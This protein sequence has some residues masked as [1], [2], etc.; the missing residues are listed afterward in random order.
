MIT[1]EQLK[2]MSDDEILELIR[3]SQGNTGKTFSETMGC[4]FSYS[5]LLDTIKRRGYVL[6]WY[7]PDWYH[8]GERTES[9]IDDGEHINITLTKPKG[10]VI[11]RTYSLD[12]DT[13]DRWS[14]LTSNKPYPSTILTYALE[15]FINDYCDG[16]IT[17]LLDNTLDIEE[18]KKNK[19]KGKKSVLVTKKEESKIIPN[20]IEEEYHKEIITE[21]VE[22]PVNESVP[23]EYVEVP[24]ESEV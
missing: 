19:K 8:P 11:R 10:E 4:D 9:I 13:A 21:E 2:S 14:A 1:K 22:E 7:N 23:E 3:K 18:I 12:K 16:K 24:E 5:H 17:L 15:N 6:D 20:E